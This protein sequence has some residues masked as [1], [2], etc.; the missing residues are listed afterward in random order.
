M[1]L[2]KED[3]ETYEQKGFLLLES[4]LNEEQMAAITTKL[5]SKSW[6]D[7][8]GTVLEEDGSL[9]AIH[10]DPTHMNVLETISKHPKLVEPAMQILGS[11]VYIH[12]LK[13]NFKAAFRG[14]VLPWH[15][16]FI[17][18]HKEDGMPEARAVNVAIFLEEVNEFNGPLCLIPGSHQEGI[19]S[20][21]NQEDRDSTNLENDEWLLNFQA[22]LKYTTSEKIVSKLVEKYG[23]EAPKGAAGSVLLFH[24]NVVHGSTNNISPLP[25]KMAIISYNSVNNIPAAVDNPRPDFIVGRDYTAIKPLVNH[26]LSNI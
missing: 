10:E 14:Q 1:Y 11:Q 26:A 9:R 18:W 8:P 15:Q 20:S 2:Q 23:I 21:L 13:I 24:P 3:Q 16:D 5:S 12:Q 17:Y 22:N 6:A 25:R 19:I 4:L 7:I